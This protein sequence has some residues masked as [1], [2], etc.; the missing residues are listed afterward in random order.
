MTTRT[1]SG[2][3]HLYFQY[4]DVDH[5]SIEFPGIVTTLYHYTERKIIRKRDKLFERS[6]DK[7]NI[8]ESNY[9][10]IESCPENEYRT[11][12]MTQMQIYRTHIKSH[13]KIHPRAT[14]KEKSLAHFFDMFGKY[15]RIIYCGFACDNREKCDVLEIPFINIKKVFYFEQLIS[16]FNTRMSTTSALSSLN[17]PHTYVQRGD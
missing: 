4:P 1:P 5:V 17:Q 15:F 13:I 11:L 12:M 2:G 7:S 3:I 16:I 14:A 8:S 10:R 6:E 9:D